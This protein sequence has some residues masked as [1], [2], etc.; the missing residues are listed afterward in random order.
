MDCVLL[1]GW[2][3]PILIHNLPNCIFKKAVSLPLHAI[4][5]I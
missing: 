3:R 5:D 2:N 4:R 1:S